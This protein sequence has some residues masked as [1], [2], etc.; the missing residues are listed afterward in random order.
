MFQDVVDL[1]DFYASPLGKITTRLIRKQ[2]R[3]L[4]P[5][6]K[7]MDLLGLGYAPPYLETFREEANHSVAIM[8]SLQ[9][10]M[11]WPRFKDNE[12]N[13]Y[14]RYKGN[15]S[16]L[17]RET[18]LPIKEASMDRVILV[19][20]LEH[21]DHSKHMLREVWR[22]LSPGG[23]VLII[24]PSRLGPWCRSEATPFGH[25]KPFS[26]NQIKK[27]LSKNMLSPT[28]ST[29][30]LFLPPFKGRTMRSALATL[31]STGQRWWSQFAGVLIIEAEKQIYAA[32]KPEAKKK[33]VTKPVIVGSQMT[34]SEE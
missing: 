22:T 14:G 7:G 5:S 24:V 21:T 15:L 34:Q 11:R 25:G 29:S 3:S 20:C 33:L 10:V 32:N 9:G 26:T 16:T 1:S 30:A 19:H 31:E 13:N 17:A 12:K 2:I 23:R 6:V 8:P 18:D 4:W 27:I 28:R